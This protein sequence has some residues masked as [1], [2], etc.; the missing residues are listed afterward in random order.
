MPYINEYIKITMK[1]TITALPFSGYPLHSPKTYFKYFRVNDVSTIVRLNKKMYDASQFTEG[2]FDHKDLFFI[3][4]S[5]PSDAIMRQFLKIA[6]NATG[7]V[8]VHC[9]AGLGRTGTLIACYLMKHYH[10]TAHE[11]IAWLRICRP[12][13][14]IGHQQQWLEE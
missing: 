13:S 8:A 6:E 3:D 2:G 10:L 5:V 9:K 14:V 4:G 7:A 1:V 12:G 11:A